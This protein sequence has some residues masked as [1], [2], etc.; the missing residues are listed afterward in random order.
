M[1]KNSEDPSAPALHQ[2]TLIASVSTLTSIA[3]VGHA[4]SAAAA[5]PLRV[6]L[7]L[8][9]RLLLRCLLHRCS[10]VLSSIRLGCGLL[11]LG[12]PRGGAALLLLVRG[13]LI[14]ASAVGPLAL[15]IVRH[16]SR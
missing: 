11:N 8:L 6:A 14:C 10:S 4:T 7:L 1:K 5:H 13:P 15:A 16:C 12:E 3:I 9:L 2:L